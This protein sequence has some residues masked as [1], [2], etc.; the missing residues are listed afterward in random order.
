MFGEGFIKAHVSLKAKKP[1]FLF[2]SN[3][4]WANKDLIMLCIVSP[5]DH[6]D[7]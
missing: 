2:K 3:N 1:Q 5:Y 6:I 4:K 7:T